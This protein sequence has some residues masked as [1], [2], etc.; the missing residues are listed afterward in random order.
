MKY[1]TLKHAMI[2]L[3]GLLVLILVY[4]LVPRVYNPGPGYQTE[5]TYGDPLPDAIHRALTPK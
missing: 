3:L 1:F 2:G 5:L 4:T